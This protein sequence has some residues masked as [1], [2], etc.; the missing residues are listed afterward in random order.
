MV[1]SRPEN[2]NSVRWRQGKKLP[3]RKQEQYMDSYRRHELAASLAKL[4][5]LDT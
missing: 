1:R 2:S 5:I 4:A 3:T